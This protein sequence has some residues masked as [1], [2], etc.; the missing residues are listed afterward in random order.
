MERLERILEMNEVDAIIYQNKKIQDP[1][2]CERFKKEWEEITTTLRQIHEASKIKT[3][4]NK[5]NE[6]IRPSSSSVIFK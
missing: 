5:N 6:V 4:T 1:I 2:F 3:E